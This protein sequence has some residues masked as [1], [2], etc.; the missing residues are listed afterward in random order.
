MR[1][2][3][4]LWSL[5]LFALLLIP[6]GMSAADIRPNAVE[7]GA[8]VLGP[9]FEPDRLLDDDY[10]REI[11]FFLEER[12]AS[13]GI[14]LWTRAA[15]DYQLFNDSPSREVAVGE[16]DWLF[17]RGWIDNPCDKIDLALRP[18]IPAGQ[19]DAVTFLIP[20]PKIHWLADLVEPHDRP[21]ACAPDARER[22]LERIAADPSGVALPTIGADPEGSFYEQDSHWSPLGRLRAA[23]ALIDHIAPGL[24]EAEAVIPAPVLELNTL[25][26]FL[27]Y[28]DDRSVDGFVVDRGVD[29]DIAEQTTG[30]GLLIW[31]RSRVSGGPVIPGTTYMFGDSQLA[32]MVPDIEQYFEELIFIGWLRTGFPLDLDS[33]PQPDRVI[34]EAVE[35]AVPRAFATPMLLDVM[36]RLPVDDG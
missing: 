15:I 23:E 22:L 10:Y 36:E 9:E 16:G 21:P 30:L 33:L 17:G 5:W 11:D 19:E 2:D 7:S 35:A 6:I 31:Q 1:P 20:L 25:R 24:W 27:G 26:R 8:L 29:F 3:L 28:R 32:F 18:A 14:G 34:V 4:R 12:T 13:R